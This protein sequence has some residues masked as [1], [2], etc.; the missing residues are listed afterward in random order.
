MVTTAGLVSEL[1]S[2]VVFLSAGDPKLLCQQGSRRV[3]VFP[4]LGV[5][6]AVLHGNPLQPRSSGGGCCFSQC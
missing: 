6:S 2:P 1:M 3:S 4:G 5:D